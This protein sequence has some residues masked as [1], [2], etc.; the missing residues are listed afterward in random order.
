MIN[1]AMNPFTDSELIEFDKFLEKLPDEFSMIV[2]HSLF[3]QK[4]RHKF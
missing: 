3:E 2:V 1:F 4:T